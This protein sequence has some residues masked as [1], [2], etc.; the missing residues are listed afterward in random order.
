MF[1]LRPNSLWENLC[2][3]I[4]QFDTWLS[5]IYISEKEQTDENVRDCYDDEKK[6][7]FSAILDANNTN[8]FTNILKINQ[9][10]KFGSQ[11]NRQ[12]QSAIL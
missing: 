3:S 8:M 2:C 1:L 5:A 4:H 7:D 6:W 9:V 11:Y 12:W 10:F